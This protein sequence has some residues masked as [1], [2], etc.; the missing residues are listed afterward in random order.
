MILH[1]DRSEAVPYDYRDYPLFLRRAWL[2]PLPK[3]G[4]QIHWHDDLEAIAVLSGQMR[5]YVNG[6][7]FL[8]AAGEGVIVN[9]RQMHAV[10]AAVREDCQYLC[11]LCH[12]MLLCVSQAYEREFVGPLLRRGPAYIRLSQ[13]VPWQKAAWERLGEICRA[14]EAGLP[15][16]PMRAQAALMEISAAVLEHL[17]A[18]EEAEKQEDSDLLAVK[19]MV[20]FIQKNYSGKITLA[21]IAAAGMAG[22]SKCCQLFRKYLHQTPVDYLTEYRLYKGMELLRGTD[23]TVSQI[24]GEVGFG[25]ASYFA[26]LF[27]KRLGTSPTAFRKKL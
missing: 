10:L 27:R 15:T 16:V 22:Q 21:Q 6:E 11:V 9:S 5:Y 23:R 20:G 13:D 26:E 25:G 14:Q 2:A 7:E 12:P 24:A 4:G 3:R 1:D 19:E 8:L 18:R 17:P